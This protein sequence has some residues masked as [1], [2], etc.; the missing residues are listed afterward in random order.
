VD[1]HGRP[2][3]IAVTIVTFGDPVVEV[4][5]GYRELGVER[6]VVGAARTGWQDP[7]TILPFLD[8]CAPMVAELA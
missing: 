6:V 3:T 1:A 8:A 4:L 7:A 5:A 2:E